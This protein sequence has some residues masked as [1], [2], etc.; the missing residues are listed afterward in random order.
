MNTLIKS[1]GDPLDFIKVNAIKGIANLK[2]PSTEPVLEKLRVNSRSWRVRLAAAVAIYKITGNL[3]PYKNSEG[4]D[5]FPDP[6]SE[7]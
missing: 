6:D 7:V 3:V 2:D 1:T 4:K 5:I